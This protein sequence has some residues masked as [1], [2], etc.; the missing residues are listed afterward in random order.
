MET[1]EIL[2][3]I[4]SLLNNKYSDAIYKLSLN[5]NKYLEIS[6]RDILE[7]DM[8]L[9]EEFLDN[10]EF[11]SKSFEVQ[12]ESITNSKIKPRF[13]ELPQ[14]IHKQ[15]W[16]IRAKD[17][18]DFITISG[19]IRRIGDVQHEITAATFEC[20]SC[21]NTLT[22]LMADGFFKK[23]KECPCG[24]K[25]GFK[26]LSKQLRDI[27]RVVIEED[28]ADLSPSQ[29]PKSMLVE[30][31]DDL[32]RAGINKDLQPSRKVKVA[33]ILRD[34]QIKPTSTECKK[35]LE[36]NNIEV[37]EES[38]KKIVLTQ[39]EKEEFHKVSG[40]ENLLKDLSQS[41][42]PT[43]RGNDD[44]KKA[45]TLQLFGGVHLYMN[46]KLEERGLIHILLVASPGTGK[47]KILKRAM[48]FMPGSQFSSGRGV[49]GVGLIAS[50]VK[51]EELG[52]WVLDAGVVPQTSGSMTVIDEL[53][54]ISR[55]DIA[56]L[57]NA[58]VDLE[59]TIHKA[60]IHSILQTDTIIL[61]AA[62]P[63][64]RVF[65]KREPVWKQIG[66]PKDLLDRFD[67][68]FPIHSS[69]EESEQRKVA[70]LIVNKYETNSELSQPTYPYEF[71]L[72]YIS[73]AR[74]NFNPKITKE[75]EDYLVDKFIN[76]VKPADP[77]EDS[78]YFSYRLLTNIIRLTQAS[79]RSR[80]SNETSTEDAR[81]AID[82]MLSSLK[83]QDIITPEGLFDYERAEA[84]QSKSKR[85][86]KYRLLDII[87]VLQ[88]S[89]LDG[90]AN[91][92]DIRS[93]AIQEDIEEPKFEEILNRLSQQGDIIETKRMKYK[94]M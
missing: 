47:T 64:N 26:I 44:V 6:Y 69:R 45:V 93:K 59:V 57:N 40:S 53:D 90:L 48:Q 75:V 1:T 10:F 78:A 41:I 21:G 16:K 49:S 52:G 51:D 61:A 60:S 13:K 70:H 24:R 84:I 83:A 67:L 25:G 39:K 37:I 80:L 34:R 7:F 91:F 50:V 66:L 88:K 9:T 73:Y 74:N 79:A 65:D 31:T 77:E 54:K 63:K 92:D 56:Y 35:F 89:S 12:L 3:K 38:I 86:L 29:K 23:P 33:G 71:V 22:I 11:V 5:N 46:N 68:I 58:M 82:I 62:N 28:P 27:Q 32:C 18:D 4:D 8:E 19:Y 55:T 14:T 76:I 72:K 43:I 87:K 81:I 30:L 20:P 15:I 36:A 94:V 85:D 2:T 17:V 42:I